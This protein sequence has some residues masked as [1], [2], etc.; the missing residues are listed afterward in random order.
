MSF[1]VSTDEARRKI[2]YLMKISRG[3]CGVAQFRPE[4]AIA[5][6]P[7]HM[8]FHVTEDV[9]HGE[10]TTLVKLVRRKWKYTNKRSPSRRS[11]SFLL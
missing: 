3:W 4:H 11:H 6:E 5:K 7:R 2:F 1:D 8:F 9:D 10:E